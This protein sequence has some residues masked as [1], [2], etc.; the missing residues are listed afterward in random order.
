MGSELVHLDQQA[1]GELKMIME[2]DF[3]L[4]VKTFIDDSIVRINDLSSAVESGDAGLLRDCAHSFKGSSS[5]ICA[6]QLSEFCKSLESMGR[7]GDLSGAD[8]AFEQIKA[9][10]A[11]VKAALEQMLE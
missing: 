10:F 1:L 2:D 4:L 7:E 11:K 8:T 5:N 9:E 3:A 6:P